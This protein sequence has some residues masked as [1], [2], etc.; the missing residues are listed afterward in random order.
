[1]PKKLTLIAV[2]LAASLSLVA[3]G[4]DTAE[5]PQADAD[6]NVEFTDDTATEIHKN[7]A[8][9][10]SDPASTEDDMLNYTTP[11]YVSFIM[12]TYGGDSYEDA[13]DIALEQTKYWEADNTTQ[14]RISDAT[15]TGTS[16][17]SY[18]DRDI[19]WGTYFNDPETSTCEIKDEWSL[20]NGTWKL[21]YS[22][23]SQCSQ[24][25]SAP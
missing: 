16:A 18:R 23:M 9:T 3:C 20:D 11:S 22:D 1:M 15:A 21:D 10:L 14:E 17:T 19:E 5:N 25:P 4:N 8:A 12:S 7:I 24:P 13:R 6:T 2:T